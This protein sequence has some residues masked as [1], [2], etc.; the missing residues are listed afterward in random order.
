MNNYDIFIFGNVSIAS[1][2]TPEGEHVIPG[3]AVL[4]STWAAHQLAYSVGLLTKTSNKDK[5]HID[6]FPLAE[7]DI[8]WRESAETTSNRVIFGTKTRETRVLTNLTQADPYKTEDFPDISAKIVQHCSP[9]AG[10]IDY[11]MIQFISNKF[12]IALDAQA[13]MRKVFPGGETEYTDWEEKRE[14]LPLVSFFKVDA[15]E[16]AVLTGFN[17]DTH[18]GRL[19]AGEKIVEWGAKEALISHHKELIAV[20]KSG[21]VF[22]PLKNRNLSGRTGRGDTSFTTYITERLTKNPKD[23]IIFAAALTSL[24][25]EIPGP[26]KKTRQDVEAFIRDFY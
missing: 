23:A 5:F 7:E 24:K 11:D 21:V 20:S 12:P 2:K 17:T 1:I 15:T 9:I 3:G 22:S 25:L 4:M 18:E 13:F 19:S 14:I 26:F 10:E 16:A 8:F 6:E